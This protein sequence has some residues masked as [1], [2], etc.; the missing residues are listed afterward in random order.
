MDLFSRKIIGWHIASKHDV[1]LKL[2]IF[3][4]IEN[5]Y[6]NHLPH[7]SIAYKTPNEFE[8]EYWGQYA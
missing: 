6:N 8:A 4:Y 3:D 2:D 5:L 1:E 7:S